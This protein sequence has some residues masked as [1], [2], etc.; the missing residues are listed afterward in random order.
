MAAAA[1][2]LFASA[3]G[4]AAAAASA[5]AF[6]GP[7]TAAASGA[8]SL[9]GIGS[10]LSTGLSAASAFG[11]IMGGNQEAAAFKAQARQSELSARA[12]ELKGRDQAD[13]IRRSLQAT[14]ASQNA[15]F[16][17]RGISLN[18]GT[19]VNLGNVSKTQAS[20]DIA[21]AQFGAGMAAEAERGSAQQQRSSASSAKIKGYTG[22]AS[23]L[24]KG[25]SLL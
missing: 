3:S 15:A 16:A 17:A 18:D 10:I 7:V 24:Y 20:Q 22:A 5:G 2:P 14:L 12:E 6:I 11:S 25:G 21:T 19:P 9:A 4:T 23:T 1:L 13:K 8:A